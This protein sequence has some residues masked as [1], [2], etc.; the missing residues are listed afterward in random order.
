MY[1]SLSAFQEVC[2]F[3]FIGTSRT[4]RSRARSCLRCRRWSSFP[5]CEPSL[6]LYLVLNKALQHFTFNKCW[7][8]APLTHIFK[9]SALFY[10][11]GPLREQARWTNSSADICTG[12]PAIPVSPHFLFIECWPE[13]FSILVLMSVDISASQHTMSRGFIYKFFG[14]DT[15]RKMP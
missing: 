9:R 3:L 15:S 14:T 4:T 7:P 10:V 12:Q 6:L 11:Q 8:C 13:H 2:C 5:C 1:A